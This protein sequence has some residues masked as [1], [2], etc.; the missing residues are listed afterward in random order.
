MQESL[1][2]Y[3]ISGVIQ[4][5]YLSG[6]S[7]SE[8]PRYNIFYD[9]F[10]TIMREAAYF[11]VRY[12]KAY[13]A[14]MAKMYD[15]RRGLKGYTVSGFI[16]NAYSAEFM[17]FNN[18]DQNLVFRE[19]TD[20]YPF[21]YGVTF[22]QE[23]TQELTLDNFFNKLSGQNNTPISNISYPESQLS[24]YS[25]QTAKQQYYD[26]KTSRSFY[27]KKEFSL[28]ANYIQ[29]QD[30]ASS[31]MAW[32]ISK[33]MKP[34][35]SV[36]IS[37]FNTPT[38]QLGDIVQISY[39]DKTGVDVVAPLSTRFIVYNIQHSRTSSGPEMTVYLSEVV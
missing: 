13:P 7:P 26:I 5:A 6:I 11:D 20:N 3:A 31:L 15:S 4:S 10:G 35:K 14:F 33:I 38:L 17:L 28:N 12:D 37:L 16:P 39:K 18:T 2:K 27:G 19:N 8:P 9:E 34:R 32:I 23:S 30:D 21:I 22:T 24:I 36:G 25:P 29:T 1:R